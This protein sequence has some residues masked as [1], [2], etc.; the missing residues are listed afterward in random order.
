MGVDTIANVSD[1]HDAAAEWITKLTAEVGNATAPEGGAPYVAGAGSATT[2]AVG[3]AL[4]SGTIAAANLILTVQRPA[5]GQFVSLEDTL[6]CWAP[7][8]NANC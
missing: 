7:D 6:V 2:G 1:A 3:V 4:T 8:L 5:Y